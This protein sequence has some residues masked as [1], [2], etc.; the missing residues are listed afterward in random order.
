MHKFGI[1]TKYAS[2]IACTLRGRPTRYEKQARTARAKIA[3][4]I[5]RKQLEKHTGTENKGSNFERNHFRNLP[6]SNGE[7]LWPGRGRQ[8][9]P[10]KNY[11]VELEI[12]CRVSKR[13]TER[14]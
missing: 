14:M 10:Q 8:T 9:R 2:H 13:H 11:A 7:R 4:K 5:S 3:S 1:R 12:R 6:S